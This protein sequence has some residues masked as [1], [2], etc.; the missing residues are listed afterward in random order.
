MRKKLCWSGVSANAGNTM[1]PATDPADGDDLV[2]PFQIEGIGVRGRLA[3][4]GALVTD[5]LTRHDY[6]EPVSVLLGEALT[7]TAMFGSALKFDGR[8]TFQ[9]QSDGPV[10]M[11]V[12]DYVSPGRLRGYAH[13]DEARLAGLMAQ[14]RL[15]E[16]PTSAE[17]LG[18]GFLAMTIDQGAK[19]E[20]YQGIVALN[21]AGLTQSAHEYFERS[22]QIAT[23]IRLA[24]GPIYH[25]GEQGR[26]E[27]TWRAGAIMIQHVARAGGITG[28]RE[29]DD[30]RPPTDE[31]ENWNRAS[32]LLGS[33][34]DHELLDPG[35]S[36]ERLLYR[37][38]HED[39]VRAFEAAPLAFGCRCS[40]ERTLNVLRSFDKAEIDGMVQNGEIIVTCEF[41]NQ[42]YKFDPRTVKE[43]MET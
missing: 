11:L 26:G 28:M 10:G 42:S 36:A 31:E 34:E 29:P 16:R 39:G 30:E 3:R 37:L 35:L 15:K 20:R 17:L 21:P 22:E 33:V 38:F 19:M 4:S 24:V 18:E 5:I 8:F 9:T 14:G 40:R 12:A 7:L 43:G 32:I 27:V 41:C 13:I 2:Q 6:P 1:A 25:R 23:R